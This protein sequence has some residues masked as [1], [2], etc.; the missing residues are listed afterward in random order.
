MWGEVKALRKKSTSSKGSFLVSRY[1]IIRYRLEG[2]VVKSVLKEWECQVC[3]RYSCHKLR[4]IKL[5]CRENRN[6]NVNR[7][8]RLLNHISD[9]GGIYGEIWFKYGKI[10]DHNH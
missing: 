9:Y 3:Y 2:G 7:N 1:L 10:W 4:V 8:Q 5:V 6:Y